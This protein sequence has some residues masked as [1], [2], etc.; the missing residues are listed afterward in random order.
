MSDII[1][2]RG[3]RVDAIVGVLAEE[4]VR[5][6]PL[7]IDIDLERPFRDAADSDDLGATTNYAEVLS[8]AQRVASQGRYMLLETLA[9]RLARKLLALDT[10][11]KAVTVAARKLDPPVPEDVDSVGVRTTVRRA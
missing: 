6:Q 3:L 7:L 1:E 4:R 11:I 9:T 10:G 8:L 5:A 2:L